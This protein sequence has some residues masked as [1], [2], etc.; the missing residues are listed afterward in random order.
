MT[1]RPVRWFP[2]LF[3]VVACN[4]THSQP[5]TLLHPVVHQSTHLYQIWE[6]DSLFLD[7]RIPDPTL[8]DTP[9]VL[10]LHG[11]GFSQG[12]RSR[13]PHVDFLDSLASKGIP[14]ASISYRL[15]RAGL[16]FGCD[17][18]A[19]EKKATVE[20]AGQDLMAALDWLLSSPLL[21]PKEWAAAGSSAGAEAALWAGYGL[22]PQQWIGVISFA[23]ALS[24]EINV[25]DSAPPLFAAHGTCDRVVPP[26]EGIHRGCQKE[27]PGAWMLC[28]GLCWAEQ[29]SAHGIGSSSYAYC[30][31]EHGVC[32]TAMLDS[33]LQASLVAWLVRPERR[34][35]TSRVRVS[36]DGDHLEGEGTCPQPCQ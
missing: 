21:L 27:A 25:T 5:D 32:N 15:T 8:G 29:L 19:A 24:Q 7:L 16:G 10:F 2:F 18:A 6:G 28:G 3:L 31:G 1:P 23:G 13:G 20:M 12:H 17:V 22:D 36:S 26:G 9:G 33:A 35:A 34:R 30:G 14:S 11:G 4:T